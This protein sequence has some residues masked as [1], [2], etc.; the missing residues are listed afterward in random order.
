MKPQTSDLK[1]GL[2]QRLL[3]I[4]VMGL[5][6]LGA[7]PLTGI[8]ELTWPGGE[9]DRLAHITIVLSLGLMGLAIWGRRSAAPRS[10]V[11]PLSRQPGG[12]FLL[13]YQ[14]ASFVV[15]RLY[16]AA[17]LAMAYGYV[18]GTLPKPDLA[19]LNIVSTE[20]V[21][22]VCGVIGLCLMIP[23]LTPTLLSRPETVLKG[24]FKA[25]LLLSLSAPIY[26]EGVVYLTSGQVA[27]GSKLVALLPNLFKSIAG[28]S[29]TGAI[30]VS[31]ATQLSEAEKTPEPI[32]DRLSES[33]LK[34]MRRARM[35]G[36]R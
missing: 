18:T 3:G 5:A 22:T 27:H 31:M 24:V 17:Y 19:L 23:P 14:I 35:G 4:A 28:L 20:A 36:L 13:S 6:A 25:L 8:V 1:P 34:K 29:I 26:F 32:Y 9:I 11:I 7:V 15:L 12:K 16:G 10:K 2:G 30:L 21:A 33:D